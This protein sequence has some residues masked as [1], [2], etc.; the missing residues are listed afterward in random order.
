[1]K[2][3]SPAPAAPGASGRRCAFLAAVAI[4]VA[5]LVAY[6][7]SFSVPFLFDDLP[8][9]VDNPTLRS[10][11]PPWGPLQPPSAHGVTVGGRPVLNLSFALNYALS[12]EAVWSY[13]ALNLLIH[14]L[15]GLTLFG[16]VRRTLVHQRW[17]SP[18]TGSTPGD[19]RSKPAPLPQRSDAG[20][21]ALVA[22]AAALLW[23]V[24]PLQT[25]SVTYIVQRAESLMGLFYLLTL[26]CF[27]RAAGA[28]TRP[29]DLRPPDHRP[30]TADRGTPIRKGPVV[31]WSRSPVVRGPV[32]WYALSF[33]CC[34]LGMATKEVMVSAP[35]LVLLYDRTFVAGSFRAAWRARRGFHLALAATWLP[36]AALVTGAA[37][38]GGTAGFGVGVTPWAYAA[39]QCRAVGQY[40]RLSF[41]PA[42]LVFDYGDQAAAHLA[43]ALLPAIVLLILLGATVAALRRRPALGFLGA[44]FFLILAPTSSVV[45]VATQIAAEHRMYLPLAAGAA[46]IAWAA[47][48]FLGRR[49]CVALLAGAVGLAALTAERNRDYRDELALWGGTV[50]KRPESVR[51]RCNL[52]VAL[53]ERGRL[54][55]AIEQYQAAL[56]LNPNSVEAHNNLGNAL[57]HSGDAAAAEAQFRAALE[58]DPGSAKAHY[59]LGT[60]RAQ[61]G[62]MA[63]AVRHLE[64]AVRLDPGYADAR[65]NL[66]NVLFQAGR[67]EE[68]VAQYRA[69]LRLKPALAETHNNLG[70]ALLELGRRDEAAPEFEEALRRRPDYD[71]ARANLERLHAMPPAP[72]R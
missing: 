55:E 51:A 47:G 33:L 37:N 46:L 13:H 30:L 59:N 17:K 12:G 56:R 19:G 66:G 15:A 24:H 18:L 69:T 72:D 67:F 36:L 64:D 42:G 53:F 20:R 70:S 21:P 54:A 7:N 22:L 28:T 2:P 3:A 6:H 50:A 29:P 63:E 43:G 41:W 27:L 9:I 49:G 65:N 32:V 31:S 10:L 38:R 11:W 26:Y 1:M 8:S 23:T 35:L 60:L 52:G 57:F 40:L 34:L 39:A 44:A 58:G 68:A 48:T 45:P 4:G 5:A 25:E 14:V 61:Q 16:I 71:K 62:R